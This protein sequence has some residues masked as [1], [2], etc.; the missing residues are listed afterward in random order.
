LL[1]FFFV[2]TETKK[3]ALNDLQN[4]ESAEKYANTLA[5]FAVIWYRLT[6]LAANGNLSPSFASHVIKSST[7]EACPFGT[8]E[9]HSNNLTSLINKK[10]WNWIADIFLRSDPPIPAR[11]TSRGASGSPMQFPPLHKTV[12]AIMSVRDSISF[13]PTQF[14]SQPSAHLI[15]SI[16]IIA[17]KTIDECNRYTFRTNPRMLPLKSNLI[18]F[19][20]LF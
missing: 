9:P 5:K 3:Q 7:K 20:F 19:V 15:H 10:A 8:G 11:P 6:V 1:I 16:R 13:T 18:Q 14:L 17:L 4:V 2:S 12:F